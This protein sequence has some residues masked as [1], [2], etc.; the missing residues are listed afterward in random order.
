MRYSINR[1]KSKISLIKGFVNPG[2]LH[3]A[4]NEDTENKIEEV[5]SNKRLEKEDLLPNLHHGW[6]W[7]D[8]VLPCTHPARSLLE[9]RSR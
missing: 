7:L 8:L 9:K 6:G 1:L 5:V 3:L 2:Q 4:L